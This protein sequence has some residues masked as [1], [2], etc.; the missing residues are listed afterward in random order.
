MRIGVFVCHCGTNIAKIIDVE[1]LAN[2]AKNWEGV[3]YSDHIKYM[4]SNPGQ[5]AMEKAIQD[6]KLE[7]VVVLACSP[8]LH[9]TTFRKV[10][11]R[12]GLN[13]YFVEIGNIREHCSWVHDDR[14][15]ATLKAIDI[16]RIAAAKAARSKALSKMYSS[17]NKNVLVIGGGIAGITAALNVAKAGFKVT[18]VEK[19]STIG[20]NMAR[21]DKTFPTLDCSSCILTPKMVE[22]HQNENVELLTYSEIDDVQGYVG[23][24]E[25]RIKKKARY[26]RE[27]ICDGCGDCWN[28]CPAFTYSEFN[29]NVG[30]RTAVYLP[31]PQAVPEIPV[32]DK[33]NCTKCYLCAK[34]CTKGAIDFSQK[35]KIIKKKF[36]AIIVATGFDIFDDSVYGEYGAG[37]FKDVITAKQLERLFSPSGP[38]EGKV[39]RPSD[40]KEPKNVVFIQCV[41]SRDPNKGV[42]YCSRVCCMY[43]AKQVN[44]LN[45][46][47][48][49][50]QAYVFYIDIRAFG[51]GYEEFVKRV[52]EETSVRYFRGRVSKIREKNGKLIVSGNDTLLGEQVEVEADLVVLANAIIAQQDAVPLSRMLGL[53]HDEFNFFTEQHPKLAPVST[54]TRG[55]FLAGTCQGPKDIPDTV[56]SGLATAAECIAL[57]NHKMLEIEP[58]IAYVNPQICSGCRACYDVCPFNAIEMVKF[59]DRALGRERE[60]AKVIETKCHGCGI[61]NPVCHVPAIELNGYT[62]EE[63]YE[64]VENI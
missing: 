53:Q 28:V 18:L 57:I 6:H 58:L 34:H 46:H 38:T 2:A 55:I 49:D 56:N 27:D 23:N 43:T 29:E 54:T 26:I 19:Y 62:S 14:E 37:K 31:F 9:E 24:F 13:Y 8:N 20:G 11:E 52:Q 42:P 5:L 48:P 61:C 44:L 36:G 30:R 50:A 25:V 22:I 39:V 41:G 15:K 64:Q 17:I 7:R 10:G 45:E 1:R 51:K 59:K 40:G 47:N 63:I 12:A 3:V 4:C 33:D 16:G 60:V 35:D 32:I 21:L